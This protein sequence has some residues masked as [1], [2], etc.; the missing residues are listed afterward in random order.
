MLFRAGPQPSGA[1]RSGPA[2]TG[3]R[4]LFPATGD[5]RASTRPR[6]LAP[7]GDGE[8]ARASHARMYRVALGEEPPF[9]DAPKYLPLLFN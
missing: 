2:G 9:A 4:V 7:G 8:A 6:R 5:G 1:Q 3:S